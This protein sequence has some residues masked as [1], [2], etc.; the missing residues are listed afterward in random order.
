[1]SSRTGSV[2][3]A[4]VRW[5]LWGAL[6]SVGYACTVYFGEEV[7]GII[8]STTSDRLMWIHTLAIEPLQTL[9]TPVF[10]HGR[11]EQTAPVWLLLAIAGCVWSIAGFLFGA[12]LRVVAE[13]F[14]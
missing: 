10:L 7:V 12:A 13:R 9:F 8:G 3:S 5:G 14:R 6:I 2:L 4:S 11:A 1:M